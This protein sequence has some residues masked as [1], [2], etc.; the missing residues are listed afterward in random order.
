MAAEEVGDPMTKIPQQLLSALQ[1]LSAEYGDR[2]AVIVDEDQS[3]ITVQPREPDPA[4]ATIEIDIASNEQVD[5]D[6]GTAGHLELY[7]AEGVGEVVNEI[8]DWVRAAVSGALV[9]EVWRSGDQVL[10]SVVR[11]RMN[12]EELKASVRT[13]RPWILRRD[14]VTYRYV[15]Y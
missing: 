6:I 13:P 2:V 3:R 7:D 12:G 4:K 14:H 15:A 5:L 1:Q 11:A 8:A 10:R 9:E